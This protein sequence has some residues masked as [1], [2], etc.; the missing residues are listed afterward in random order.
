M[1]V[2]MEDFLKH[3]EQSTTSGVEKLR[4]DW[5]PE[6]CAI[7]DMRREEV[8]QWMPQD[9]EVCIKWLDL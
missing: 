1:P 6:C 8:E 5:L 4:N 9:N 3:V 7:V 2:T